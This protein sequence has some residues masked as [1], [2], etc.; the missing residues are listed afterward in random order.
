MGAGESLSC[1]KVEKHS[2]KDKTK[3]NKMNEADMQA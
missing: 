1:L 2:I 3:H